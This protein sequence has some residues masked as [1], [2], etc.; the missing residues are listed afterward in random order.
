MVGFVPM[1]PGQSTLCMSTFWHFRH[2]QSS[3]RAVISFA[4]PFG[5]KHKN[6]G[7]YY[8]INSILVFTWTLG[9]ECLAFIT[10]SPLSCLEL[11]NKI[12]SMSEW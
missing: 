12:N 7:I 2:F 8:V 11:Q 9:Q 4:P 10:N 3:L 5:Q 6:M 1:D